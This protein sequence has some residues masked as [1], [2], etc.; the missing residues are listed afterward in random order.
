MT[1]PKDP[2]QSS[3]LSPS[4][5]TVANKP[6]LGTALEPFDQPVV[7]RQPRF[8]SRAI[9]WSLMGISTAVVIWAS[10]A[11]IDEAISAQGKLEPEGNVTEVQAPIGG[12]VKEVLV[13]EGEKV[14]QGQV[15]VRL[16]SAGAKAQLDSLLRVEAALTEENSFYRSI[17]QGQANPDG[18]TIPVERLSLTRN[19]ENLVAENQLFMAQLGAGSGALSYN[20]QLRLQVIQAES[21]SRVNAAEQE[22]SQLQRQ[23]DQVKAQLITAEAQLPIEQKI[24]QDLEPLLAEGGIQRVQVIRQQQQVYNR[25]LDVQRFRQETQRLQAAIAQAISRV[26]NTVSLSQTD[27]LARMADN[28]Q[29]IAEID[30]QL[31]KIILDND[32]RLAETKSQIIQT[33]KTI[34]YQD[35]TAPIAGTVFNLRAAI[36]YVTNS[37]NAAI[38]IFKI[39][40]DQALVARVFITNQDIGFVREGLPVDVR[41][42]SFPFSEFG[43]VKGTLVRIGSDALPPDQIYNYY[44]FPATIKMDRQNLAINGRQIS[45]QSGMSVT[46]NIKLRKRSVISIF[47]DLFTNKVGSLQNVR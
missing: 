14:K 17:L 2:T 31:S 20:Q 34:N 7:L 44:R 22:V 40:P 47:S 21:A 36:G 25:Q 12:V 29:R 3:L 32:K 35:I 45:L 30:S 27:V 1:N 26:Q 15:L 38:P 41:V 8:W 24:L 10:F 18:L 39:V 6:E 13:K 33:Q 23:L 4:S 42:D 16:D 9:A 28:E 5:L 43:D 46:G 37:A 19:R 11:Q